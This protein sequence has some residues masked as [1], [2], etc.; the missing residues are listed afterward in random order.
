MT[1][2]IPKPQTLSPKSCHCAGHVK[3]ALTY[4][5]QRIDEGYAEST[6]HRNPG[7]HM[8]SST[9]PFSCCPDLPTYPSGEV[10]LQA[11]ISLDAKSVLGDPDPRLINPLPLIGLIIGILIFGPLKGGAYSSYVYITPFGPHFSES[12]GSTS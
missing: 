2:R 11:T 9:R 3:L 4:P 5:K 12:L 10:P 7:K 1:F 6:V 8:T